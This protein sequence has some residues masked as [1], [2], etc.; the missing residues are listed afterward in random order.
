MPINLSC[1]ACWNG[2]KYFDF[3]YHSGL[4]F[5]PA[6]HTTLNDRSMETLFGLRI[7]YSIN[8]HVRQKSR[9]WDRVINFERL[10]IYALIESIGFPG[11]SAVKNSAA[12]A[13][14]TKDVGSIP[15]SGRSSGGGN[16]NPPWYSCLENLMDR[17]AWEATV[18]GVAK[19]QARLSTHEWALD[20]A[21]THRLFY[22]EWNG[23][24]LKDLTAG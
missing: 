1:H 13:G 19:G 8:I 9:H 15:G 16:S 18:H 7:I 22:S 23:K 14:D 17:G 11:G 3:F 20:F 4:K 24:M 2:G 6:L 10:K 5:S 21:D 12:N